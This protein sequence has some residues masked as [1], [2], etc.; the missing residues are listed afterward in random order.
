MEFIMN[1]KEMVT[2][3]NMCMVYDGDRVLAINKVY[4]GDIEGLTFPGGHVEKGE[5][6]VDS[7]IREVYEETGLKIFEPKLCGIKSW[8]EDDGSRYMVFMYKT[9]KYEGELRASDG[10]DVFWIS[11]DEFL[12]SKLAYSTD[13]AYELMNNDEITESYYFKEGEEWKHSFK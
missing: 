13:L 2:L 9:D 3:T 4:N 7:V 8:V 11:R 5:S 6:F 12:K 1:R 10:G